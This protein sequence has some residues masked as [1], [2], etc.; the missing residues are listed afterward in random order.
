MNLNEI[1]NKSKRDINAREKLGE[2]MSSLAFY[3]SVEPDVL[4]LTKFKELND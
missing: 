2:S 1:A 3:I 4:L